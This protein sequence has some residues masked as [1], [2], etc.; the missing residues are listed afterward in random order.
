[1]F[2]ITSH[3]GSCCGANHIYSFGFNAEKERV[4]EFKSSLF[5]ALKN[6]EQKTKN[7][8]SFHGT[9]GYTE[10]GRTRPWDKESDF[11]WVGRDYSFLIEITLTDKQVIAWKKP[12]KEIGFKFHRRWFNDNSGNYVS[13]L[14]YVPEET[15][16]DPPPFDWDSDE[17]T[18]EEA[19]PEKVE[20]LTVMPRPFPAVTPP[21]SSW[22][23][24]LQEYNTVAGVQFL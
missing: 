14:T 23:E 1:M 10:D 17:D 8:R 20:E 21:N 3:G 11:R 19:T 2:E 13:L 18:P 15:P 16:N 9:D 22:R 4:E 5:R 24:F 12:L 7:N 6:A